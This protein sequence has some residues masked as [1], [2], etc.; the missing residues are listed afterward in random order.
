PGF[1]LRLAGLGRFALCEAGK[2]GGNGAVVGGGV[3]IH[4][5]GQF[6]T[7]S[8]GRHALRAIDVGQDARIVGRV[9]D[10]RDATG[11]GAVVLGSGAKHGGAV[12]VEVLE[13]VLEGAAGFRDV[14]TEGVQVDH[15]HVD[16]V[17]AVFLQG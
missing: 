13:R 12:D 5:G 4:L 7:Q 15:Q 14:L 10:Y 2:V 9:D 3:G 17:D 6:Q 16:A 8:V 1:A 11:F